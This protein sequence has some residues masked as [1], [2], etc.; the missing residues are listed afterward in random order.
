[1]SALK[2]VERGI[3]P[4]YPSGDPPSALWSAEP[5]PLAIFRNMQPCHRAATNGRQR[6]AHGTA[7][8][9]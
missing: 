9:A 8:N 6:E 4:L 2:G 3:F 7:A 1:M 5:R